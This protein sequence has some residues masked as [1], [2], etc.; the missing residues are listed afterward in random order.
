[1]V[2]TKNIVFFFFFFLRRNAKFSCQKLKNVVYYEM[3]V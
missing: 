1:M 3:I 2:L